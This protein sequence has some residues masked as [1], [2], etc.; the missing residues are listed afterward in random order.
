[1]V[2]CQSH[3]CVLWERGVLKTL[4][5]GF[6]FFCDSIKFIYNISNNEFL[7]YY[8]LVKCTARQSVEFLKQ[9]KITNEDE[10]LIQSNLSLLMWENSNTVDYSN[11]LQD[12]GLIPI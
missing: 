5:A 8:R 6:P 3:V 4:T 7:K 12:P 9:E 10:K 1:M 2:P 11:N